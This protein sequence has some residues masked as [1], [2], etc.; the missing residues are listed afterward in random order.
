[1]V[2]S[3]SLI[4][5]EPGELQIVAVE[6]LTDITVDYGTAFGGITLPDSLGVTL[7]DTS[8]DTLAVTWNQGSYDGNTAGTYPIHGDLTLE[9]GI[10]NPGGLQ[11]IFIQILHIILFI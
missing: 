1:M 8:T 7:D 11:G 10:I 3:I 2:D 9:A 5:G 4:Y 6:S